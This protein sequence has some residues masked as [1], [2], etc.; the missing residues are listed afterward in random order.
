[1][2]LVQ[3][4]SLQAPLELFVHGYQAPSSD[5][6][7]ALVWKGKN[8]SGDKTLAEGQLLGSE[9]TWAQQEIRH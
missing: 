1:M 2:S 9:G 8:L 5:T 6:S 4:S 7:L 3:A